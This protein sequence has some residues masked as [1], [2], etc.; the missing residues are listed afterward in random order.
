MV[1]MIVVII[2]KKE[3]RRVFLVLFLS[4]F[5]TNIICVTLIGGTLV[6][7]MPSTNYVHR[8][9][10][11]ISNIKALLLLCYYYFCYYY[12]YQWYYQY[13]R[14][15]TLL[16]TNNKKKSIQFSKNALQKSFFF[17]FDNFFPLVAYNFV[18]KTFIHFFIQKK[19]VS[20]SG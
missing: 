15:V 10:Q 20:P 5:A 14:W 12:M 11:L 17:V 7:L 9:C 18:Q 19:G 1:V 8:Y 16:T 2:T 6:F 3:V 4:L 13:Y